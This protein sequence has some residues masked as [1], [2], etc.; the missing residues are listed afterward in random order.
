MSIEIKADDKNITENTSKTKE[1]SMISD[2]S[3]I[4]DLK[5]NNQPLQNPELLRQDIKLTDDKVLEVNLKEKD[6]C[7]VSPFIL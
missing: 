2:K 5:V 3:E 6:L 7:Y 4:I 1:I